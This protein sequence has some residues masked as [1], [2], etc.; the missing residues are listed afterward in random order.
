ML[1]NKL[2]QQLSGRLIRNIGW[3]GGA[4]LLNRVFRLGT[5]VFIARLLGPYDYGLIAII[6]TINDFLNVF[7]LRGGIGGKIIQADGI[8]VK[9]IC[10]TA[11]WLNWIIC[12]FLLIIQCLASFPIALFYGDNKLILPICVLAVG[13][14]IP[15]IFDVQSA[16]LQ[17]EN[18]LN[19]MA[20]CNV[21]QSILGNILT[22]GLAFLGMGIW[23]VVLPSILTA[24][25]WI[26]IHYI[27]H[28]WRPPK[29]FTLKE[30]QE[31][32][33]FGKNILGV[34]LLDRLR[35]NLDYL[36]IGHF[37]GVH[38]LGIYYFAFNAGLGISLSVMN[39]LLIPLFP[40][41]SAARGNFKQLKK[42]YF[43]SIKIIA[44]IFVPL[45]LLQSS[46]APFYVPIVFG[47]KWVTAIPILVLICLSALPRPFA[48]TASQ[49]LQ[50]VDKT[51]I[52][53]YWNLIFTVIFAGFLLVAVK[54]GIFWVAASVLICHALLLPI[55]TV[56]VIKYVF[57]PNS[58]FSL[59]R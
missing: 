42:Q 25:V 57:A 4:E 12:G 17:R 32:V 44:L 26:V 6:L 34:E 22:I 16:L 52:S 14:L 21:T 2:K 35:A 51:Q 23:A 46:L 27:N 11:Y 8:D 50:T 20:L 28:P 38:A 30:W 55:F 31:I 5:T 40:H 56:L 45:V 18:R 7:S 49:L 33:N 37:L 41:L 3:L 15:P 39:V 54:W 47:Q 24:P 59:P 1:I 48:G 58:H 53:L 29:F 9:V 36:L 13:Y 19:V 10:N 43:S